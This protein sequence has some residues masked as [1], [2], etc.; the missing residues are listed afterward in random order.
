MPQGAAPGPRASRRGLSQ[1]SVSP[2]SQA[3]AVSIMNLP[4]ERLGGGVAVAAEKGWAPGWGL[5][6]MMGCIWLG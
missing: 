3:D 4:D 6:E 5:A 1:S 2:Y